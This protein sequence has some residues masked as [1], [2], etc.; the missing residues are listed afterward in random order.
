MKRLREWFDGLAERERRLLIIFVAVVGAFVLLIVPYLAS[1]ALDSRRDEIKEFRTAIATVQASRD[2]VADRHVKRDTI[3]ARYSNK[4]PPLAGF[5]ESAA[6]GANIA[7]PESQDLSD[8]PHGKRFVERSTQ[9]R[10]R[11]VGMLALIRMIEK[12]EGSGFAIVISKLHVRRRGGETD[13]YDVEMS[14]SAYDPTASGSS[15]EAKVDTKTD[16]GKPDPKAD[17]APEAAATGSARP[18]GSGDVQ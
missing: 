5:I 9:V 4:A 6:K 14:V 15:K 3:A 10:L 11:K 1:I 18:V 2:K 13:S 7:I 16:A 17:A 8:I 12:I